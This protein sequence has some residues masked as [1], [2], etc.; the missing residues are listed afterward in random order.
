MKGKI[1]SLV[2]IIVFTSAGIAQESGKASPTT[3]LEEKL[4]QAMQ[5]W[6]RPDRLGGVVAVLQEGKIVYKKCFGQANAEHQNPNTPKTVYDIANLA[7]PITGMAIAMLEERGE[8][9]ATDSVRKHIP[10]LPGFTDSITIAHLL[11]HTSGLID[12]F[13]LLILAGWNERDVITPDHVW[14]LLAHQTE[15]L[16]EPGSKY[17]YSRTDYTVLA[18]VV[19]RISNQSFREWAWDNIFKPLKMTRTLVRDDHREIIENRAYSISYSGY[20][21]YLRGADNLAVVGSTSLF[22]TLDDFIKWMF[23]LENHEIGSAAL[24]TKMAASGKLADGR[25]TGHSYGF[26]LDTYQ[27]LKRMYKNGSWGGFRTAFHYYP[28]IPFGVV[29]FANWDYDVYDPVRTAESLSQIFLETRIAREKESAPAPPEQKPIEMSASEL[30]TY[31]GHYR[32]EPG[33]YLQIVLEGDNLLAKVSGA[34]FRLMP[35]SQTEFIVAEIGLP[36][37][38]EK[39]AEGRIARFTVQG[40][41]APRVELVEL[42]LEQLKN[43]KGT[44]VNKALD[45]RYDIKLLDDKLVLTSPRGKEIT[46]RPENQR[47]FAGRSRILHT[48]EF[49][50]DDNHKITGFCINTDHLRPFL[51]ERITP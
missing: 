27:G 48:I 39:D 51:F 44:Y 32:M 42:N 38:F 21:G 22:T 11:Y 19:K 40:N 41:T 33:S 37:Y 20:E 2:L 43:Y 9:A 4:K 35:L 15:P 13:D 16:F 18:E 28:E 12:W 1:F 23:N 25:D 30:K 24:M 3:S 50:M 7:E 10:E 26:C 49:K 6:D 8:V 17:L 45:M 47:D 5:E 31:E 46:L 29:V 14:K 34:S 36:V